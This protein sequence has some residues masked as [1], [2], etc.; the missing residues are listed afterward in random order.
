M[1]TPAGKDCQH[2]HEDFHRGKNV[3]E[4]RLVKDNPASLRW[5]P[6]D[7]K[8]CPIPEI[9]NANASQYLELELTIKPKLLGLGRQ[10]EVKASCLK[11]RISISDPYVGCPKCNEE[12]PG[13]KLFWAALEDDEQS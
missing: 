6:S 13:L 8:N 10:N 9:L 4:C 2:Y 3:Q 11:H 5:K 7:C 1:R 12:R